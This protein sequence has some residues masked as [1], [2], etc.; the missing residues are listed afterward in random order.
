MTDIYFLG[1]LTAAT[2]R[3]WRLTGFGKTRLAT[4]ASVNS[5]AGFFF[6][7]LGI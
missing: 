6:R 3:A 1:F 4:S 2:V 5:C 7:F